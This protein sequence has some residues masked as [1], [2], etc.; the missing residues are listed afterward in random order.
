MSLLPARLLVVLPIL[1]FF[2]H[3]RLQGT[4]ISIEPAILEAMGSLDVQGML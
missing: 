2:I 1:Y 3:E 4:S